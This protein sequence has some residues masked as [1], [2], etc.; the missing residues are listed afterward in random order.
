MTG[1]LEGQGFD[2]EPFLVMID[3]QIIDYDVGIVIEEELI[4]DSSE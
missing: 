1:D 4:T 2:S 3:Q